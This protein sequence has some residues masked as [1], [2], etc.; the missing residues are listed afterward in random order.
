MRALKRGAGIIGT[1]A[2]LR[3]IILD[4][5]GEH[6]AALTAPTTGPGRRLPVISRGNPARQK[7]NPQSRVT[8]G[9]LPLLVLSTAHL[10]PPHR[11]VGTVLWGA[12]EG[13]ERGVVLDKSYT[14]NG[15]A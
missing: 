12:V 9:H 3:Y 6:D 15:G 1:S 14:K 8:E 13:V 7:G 5:D 11:I 2:R 4:A 10:V